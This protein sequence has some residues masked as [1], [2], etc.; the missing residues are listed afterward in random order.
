M[1]ESYKEFATYN[2]LNYIKQDTDFRKYEAIAFDVDGTL[3]DSRLSYNE[4]IYHTVSMFFQ[5][6]V[7]FKPPKDE[8]KNSIAKLRL[9]GGFNN[10]WDTSYT[11][12]I[13]LFSGLPDELLK[14]ISSPEYRFFKSF[15]KIKVNRES[16]TEASIKALNYLLMYADNRGLQSIEEG[17][18]KLYNKKD[19]LN[20]LTEIK[21][22]LNY[23][24]LPG[25]SILSSVFEEL[26]LGTDL[27]TEMWQV[28]PVFKVKKG[29]IE[30]EK[31]VLDNDVKLFIKK[32]FG[33]RIGIASGRP[34]KAAMRTLKDLIGSFF[35]SEGSFFIDDAYYKSKDEWLGKPNPFLIEQVFKSLNVRSC[36][37]IGDSYEDMLMVKNA[38]DHGY[39]AGFVGVYGFSADPKS[40]VHKFIETGADAV[41]PSVNDIKFLF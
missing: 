28:E 12:L 21:N 39:E 16:L 37:Y 10:D 14:I 33:N 5:W 11:I 15:T 6:S 4:T 36:L 31:V 23:P 17:I 35:N 30:E 20:Y 22:K 19:K 13:G 25:K 29:L 8:I 26:Y 32:R 7:G 40:F 34:R 27:Y 3:V 18:R 1:T 24:S 2:G 41:L 9:T 38:K